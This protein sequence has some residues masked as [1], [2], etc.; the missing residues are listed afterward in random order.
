MLC[1]GERHSSTLLFIVYF[2]KGIRKHFL[3][4]Q[5]FLL[6][7]SH[8]SFVWIMIFPSENGEKKKTIL[9]VIILFRNISIRSFSVIKPSFRNEFF[10]LNS[11]LMAGFLLSLIIFFLP[12]RLNY[13]S[14]FRLSYK[15]SETLPSHLINFL[16]DPTLNFSRKNND[17]DDKK[18]NLPECRPHDNRLPPLRSLWQHLDSFFAFSL[19]VSSFAFREDASKKYKKWPSNANIPKTLIIFLQVFKAKNKTF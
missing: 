15:W 1:E 17:D 3:R 16:C 4:Q 14:F 11:K 9:K 18:F 8:F 5:T 7:T 19:M 10:H 13:F 12:F 6:L 2:C